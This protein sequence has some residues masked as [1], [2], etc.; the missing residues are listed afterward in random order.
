M[1]SSR[2]KSLFTFWLIAFVLFCVTVSLWATGYSYRNSLEEIDLPKTIKLVLSGVLLMIY[3][4]PL[5]LIHNYARQ[6]HMIRIMRRSLF[7]F[8]T[9]SVAALGSIITILFT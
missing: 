4:P 6:D 7:L 9:I 2:S 3:C 1:H 5:I 8:V